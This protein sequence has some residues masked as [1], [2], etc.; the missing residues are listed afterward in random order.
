MRIR[1]WGG[2]KSSDSFAWNILPP[3]AKHELSTSKVRR[4]I[5]NTSVKL[6]CYTDAGHNSTWFKADNKITHGKVS[7]RCQP[8]QVG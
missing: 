3:A 5:I 4:D 7:D 1:K 6:F 8:T 2:H